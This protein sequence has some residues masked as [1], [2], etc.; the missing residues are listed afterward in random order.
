MARIRRPRRDTVQSPLE[1]YLREI[2]ET[3]L[4]NA[5]E[6]KTLARRIADGAR[7]A[8]HSRSGQHDRRR[9]RWRRS[10]HSSRGFAPVL[11][12]RAGFPALRLLQQARGRER[13]AV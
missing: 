7:S 11:R 1:T 6:E 9:R 10:A 2:N 12:S 5:D 13:G 8:R 3:A 4:L